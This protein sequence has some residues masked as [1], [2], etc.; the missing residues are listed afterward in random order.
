[1]W[2]SSVRA[3]KILGDENRLRLLN[4]LLPHELNVQELTGILGIGQSRVSRHLKQL[5]DGGFL[6]SRRDG[7]WAY[8]R[9]VDDGEPRRLLDSVAYLFEA[10][11]LYR[12]DHR[13]AAE[14]LNQGRAADLRFFDSVA[15]EWERLR[16]EILGELDLTS[17][18]AGALPELDK[19][20]VSDLGCGTG[21]LLPFLARKAGTVI[22]VDASE[23]M[24]LEARRRLRR[25]AATGVELRLGELEH[26]PMR[27]GESDWVVINL[28]LHHL[29]T[30]AAGIREAARVIRP[31]GGLIAVDLEK[32]REELLRSRF[33]DRWLGFSREELESWLTES[34]FR[35]EEVMEFPLR[36][37]LTA[38]LLRAHKTLAGLQSNRLE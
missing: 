1:M 18:I 38:V 34:G 10:E 17:T 35:V 9:V 36:L 15:P 33:G 30:P 21:V 2:I 25:E 11:E 12:S 31:G 3:F 29:R 22:G 13:V 6:L 28:V 24:L 27:D 26:L 20:V 37:G 19:G 8:Y 5:S 16:L 4:L 23:R 7:L 32:H 14:V